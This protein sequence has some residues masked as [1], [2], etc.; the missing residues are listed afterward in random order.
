MLTKTE[1]NQRNQLEKKTT[2]VFEK[3]QPP[4]DYLRVV[5]IALLVIASF[6]LG[7]MS[8]GPEQKTVANLP[9][10][11]NLP[12]ATP[13]PTIDPSKVDKLAVTDHLRG[14]KNA[15]FQL[16]VYSD[17]ECPFSKKFQT[18]IKQASDQYKNQVAVVYRHFPLDQIHSKTRKEAQATECAAKLAGNEG[19]WRLTDKIYETTNSNNSLDLTTLPTLAVQVGLDKVAF[20]SCLDSDSVAQTVEAQYQSG[21][22]AGVSGTPGSFLVDSRTGTVK[23]ISGAQP[24]EQLKSL[25]DSALSQQQ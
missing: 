17:L 14:D 25:I 11:N 24:L 12:V 1:F 6:L 7:K 19:F 9:A 2:Q 23:F 8:T 5:L 20:Q 10:A 3:T 22:R 16:I 13:Q 15:R 18:T 4:K 21:V